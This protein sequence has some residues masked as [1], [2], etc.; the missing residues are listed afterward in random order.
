MIRRKS[1]FGIAAVLLLTLLVSACSGNNAGTAPT[2]GSS[3]APTNESQPKEGGSLIIA[4][5]AD[6]VI[7][8]PNYAGDR[9]SL[10]IDQALYAPLFQVNN[11]EKTFYLAESLEPSEDNLTYTLKLKSGLT[12]HDGEKLTA[13]DVVFTIDKILDE[14]QNSF[15]R[16]NF[17]IGG[18]PIQAV[19]VDDLTVE[20]KLP[21]VSPAF[22]ATLVQVSPIPKHIFEN[23]ADLEKS[24][25]NKAP[26]G[27]GAF[28]FKEYKTGEYVTLERFD[29]YVGGKP[30]LDSITYRIAKDTNSAN[31]ALQNGEINVKYVDPQDVGT[32]QASNKF[33]ILPYSEGRLSYLLFNHNSDTGVLGKKEVRQALSYALNRDELIQVAYTSNEYADPAKSILAPD[34]LFQTNDLVSFDNDAAKAK[35]LLEAAG[36]KGLKLR[37]IVS[38]GNKAQ[39]SISLYVQQK[40]KAVGVDVE[41]KAMDASAYGEKFT[42]PKAT[43]YELAA[44]GYIMGY[45]PDA[46]SILFTSDGDANYSHYSNKE[47]DELFKQGASE[48]DTAKRGDIYKKLQEIA[49]EDAPVYPIAYT[50]TIVAVDK[51]YGGLEEAV[52]K[53]VVI[54]E[55]LSKIYLK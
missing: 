31:L 36:V 48:A 13:D 7:L 20:F 43:D 3:N 32:I 2:P 12:W 53:P 39:E 4:V 50:K 55:D 6:P 22:E 40:L 23:E 29:G 25:K 37:F 11:G 1:M 41:I 18:K 51:K 15:L 27:S 24:T 42:N 17:T 52:L 38:S 30:Y 14:K 8:N 49:A 44:A 5:G 45:D 21:Q 10:T 33:E 34:A 9:V 35:E 19:K 16:G 54:F 47:V 46:Y 28:K 26:I